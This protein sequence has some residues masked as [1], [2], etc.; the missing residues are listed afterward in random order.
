MA[1]RRVHSRK[2]TKRRVQVGGTSPD[3]GRSRLQ[4]EGEIGRSRN[5]SRG[6][7]LE[8]YLKGIRAFPLLTAAE[9]V[10]L[11]KGME[12]HQAAIAQVLLRYP[13]VL[14]EA[15]PH[16]DPGLVACLCAQR[17]RVTEG[18]GENHLTH[19]GDGKDQA[20]GRKEDQRLCRMSSIFVQI[21]LEDAQ[22]K[23]FIQKIG[24]RADGLEAREGDLR[25]TRRG[26][27]ERV[28]RIQEDHKEL[29]E[30]YDSLQRARKK[31][32]ESNLRLVVHIAKRYVNRGLCFADLIQEGNFGLLRAVIK[33]EYRRGNKFSTYAT[34][35]IRQAIGRAVREQAFAVRLPAH[36]NEKIGKLRRSS[37]GTR[38][39]PGRRPLV[40]DVMAEMDL[41]PEEAQRALWLTREKGVVSLQTPVAEGDA[42]LGDFL[43]DRERDSV[44]DDCG[45]I[46]LAR[47]V[48]RAVSSLEPREA[49]IL[50]KRF[51]IG[52]PARCTLQELSEE[53]GVSRER[54]RQIES[55]ALGKLR[56]SGQA[57]QLGETEDA[58]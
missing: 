14:H 15:A 52:M 48:R 12:I 56:R 3:R 24:D 17:T 8:L 33:F 6:D 22:L 2:K 50:R 20:S 47:R 34:F 55:C 7:S 23:A 13:D 43:T 44:E 40:E 46:E 41:R 21:D 57:F 42:E 36:V 45:R 49:E 38:R 5:D 54:V 30:A 18:L 35:W 25:R 9:E 58:A 16:L 29:V 32:I 4:K 28:Q 1:E 31:M 51:G 11:A 19:K 39:Y 27:E 37:E 53:Q 26:P 10:E